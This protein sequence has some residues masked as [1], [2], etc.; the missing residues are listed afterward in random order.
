MV[1]VIPGLWFAVGSWH[2]SKMF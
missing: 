1:K 2:L